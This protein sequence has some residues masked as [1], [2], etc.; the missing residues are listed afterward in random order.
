MDPALGPAHRDSKLQIEQSSG[1]FCSP[2]PA[3]KEKRS[4]CLSHPCGLFHHHPLGNRGLAPVTGSE[5]NPGRVL[6]VIPGPQAWTLRKRNSRDCAPPP[7]RTTALLSVPQNS[8]PRLTENW[9]NQMKVPGDGTEYVGLLGRRICI[10]KKIWEVD[11]DQKSLSCLQYRVIYSY[12]FIGKFIL[13]I[14][15]YWQHR[16]YYSII[17]YIIL[18]YSGVVLNIP[19]L[20]P[21]LFIFGLAKQHLGS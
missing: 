21:Y 19:H 10:N 1:W 12:C 11:F 18:Y 15:Q 3:W 2:E 4:V 17:F 6:E 13:L 14:K 8:V 20:L 16:L 5:V 9:R 7:H